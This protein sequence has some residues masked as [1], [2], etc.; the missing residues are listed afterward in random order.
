MFGKVFES[1]FTGSMVGAGPAVFAVWVYAIVHSKPPG[2][3]E[4]N[5]KLIAASLGCTE[6][7]VDS[8]IEWL[9]KPD[10]SSRSDVDDGRRLVRE[11]PF[12]YRLPTWDHY[13]RV[14]DHEARKA[15]WRD[16]KRRQRSSMSAEDADISSCRPT[17][18]KNK[19]ETET[20]KLSIEPVSVPVS[21]Q[22]GEG[23]PSQL[24]APADPGESVDRS[25][26]VATMIDRLTGVHGAE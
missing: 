23:N 12:L 3:V 22:K 15:Q 14:R 18:N 13:Q 4:L 17:K 5:S 8:A 6:D 11:G 1:M 2:E 21:G 19:T 25:A 9:M 16:Q 26:D 20:Q 10:D 7:E 24:S